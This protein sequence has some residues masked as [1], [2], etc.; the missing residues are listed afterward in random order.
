MP[1]FNYKTVYL[2]NLH[3][4]ELSEIVNYRNVCHSLMFVGKAFVPLLV[5]FLKELYY[6]N[7]TLAYYAD[8]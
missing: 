4:F 6:S 2:C 7:D 1:G 3:L 8:M 5:K